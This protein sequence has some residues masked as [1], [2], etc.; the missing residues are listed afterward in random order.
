[1]TQNNRECI[2]CKKLYHY[3][4]RGCN[5]SNVNEQWRNIYCSQT[6]REIFHICTTKSLSN[7]EAYIRLNKLTLPSRF[8]DG[9]QK[10]ID[11]IQSY[12][13]IKKVQDV[14]KKKNRKK[15][16]VNEED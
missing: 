16:I 1:M 11:R 12:E 9:I 2:V 8:S 7:E 13:P 10:E 14:P 5:N 6:C 15:K 4:S 3:C